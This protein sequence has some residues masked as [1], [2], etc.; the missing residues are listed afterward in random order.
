MQ[1]DQLA[2]EPQRS[3]EAKVSISV[4]LIT[5]GIDPP[6]VFG[7]ATALASAGISV[8]VI[9]SDILDR[10]EMHSNSR[11]RFLNLQRTPAP[12][13]SFPRR[14]WNLLAYYARLLRYVVTSKPRVFHILWN[15]KLWLLDRTILPV[16]FKAF[17]NV[18]VFTAHNVNTRER[19]GNDSLLN[20]VTLRMQYRQMDHI[21]VH[22][23][24][25]KTQLAKEFN[26]S[27]RAITVIPF[28]INN[29][30]PDSNISSGESRRRLGIA[31]D[32]RAILFY[33]RITRYK[34][35]HVLLSAF[36]LV[37]QHQNCRLLIAGK[38]K[39]DSP[40]YE[41]QIA[42]MVSSEGLKEHITARLEY[43]PDEDTE[44][45]FKAADVAVLP[46]TS[47]FQSGVLF[48]AYRFGLPVIA[49]DVG[50]FRR[51][52]EEGQTGFLFR[53]GDATDLADKIR[54]YFDSPLF[55]FLAERRQSIQQYAESRHSWHT[56]AQVT[57][58]VYNHLLAA[59]ARAA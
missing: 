34:G 8:D 22:T 11:I 47:I 9:G 41:R 16:L 13:F 42:E 59:D 35:L 51:D 27:E 53:P 1:A 17:G 56:V 5:G 38:P 32:E 48:L 33:G 50:N 40:D 29:S 26:V 39:G 7:L 28:G 14:V 54:K 6:Y 45:Y 31:E 23:E 24:P 21:F 4:A 46:Y 57:R 19:D 10:P 12:T 44:L 3:E 15:N 49:S 58:H 18:L 43:I 30:V 25:M 36:K 2:T 52:I 55:E 37:L 20:R